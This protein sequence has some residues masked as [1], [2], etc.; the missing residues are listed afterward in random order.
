MMLSTYAYMSE[1]QFF[2]NF[3][4]YLFNIDR[5]SSTLSFYIVQMKTRGTLHLRT[6]GGSHIC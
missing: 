5:V 1:G 4:I 2:H 3:N 6:S